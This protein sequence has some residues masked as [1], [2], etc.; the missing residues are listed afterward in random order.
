MTLHAVRLN[1]GVATLHETV[2]KIEDDLVSKDGEYATQAH[3]SW[4]CLKC[5]L[6]SPAWSDTTASAGYK[7]EKKTDFL[8]SLLSSVRGSTYRLKIV[9]IMNGKV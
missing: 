7:T 5:K 8:Q 9:I 2:L 6:Y 4:G 3:L 1:T